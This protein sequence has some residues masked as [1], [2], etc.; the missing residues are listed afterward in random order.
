[1]NAKPEARRREFIGSAAAGLLIVKPQTAFGSAANST[2]EVGL[3]GCGGRGNWIAP[4]FVEFAG[5][6]VVALADV[7][8]EHLDTTRAKL[9]NGT[10]RVYY[11]PNAYRELAHSSLDAVIIETPPYFHPDHAMAAVEAESMSSSPSRWP[12]TCPGA[13]RFSPPARKQSRKT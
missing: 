10:G 6:R 3:I 12:W 4:F 1:M 5:A 7:I 11:G 8:R 2:V 13:R 9:T